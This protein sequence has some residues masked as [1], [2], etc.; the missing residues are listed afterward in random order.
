M[1]DRLPGEPPPA[2]HALALVARKLGGFTGANKLALGQGVHGYTCTVP[3]GEVP[4]LWD[5]DGQRYLPGPTPPARTVRLPVAARA[6]RLTPTPTDRQVPLPP[7]PKLEPR[8]GQ[9]TLKLTDRPVFLEPL[10]G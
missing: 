6:Y 8:D 3:T 4:V 10:E 9:L 2:Y 5:D 7:A 1:A